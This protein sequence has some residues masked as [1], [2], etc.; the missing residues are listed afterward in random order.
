ML[1]VITATSE[2]VAI[3][4]IVSD[5]LTRKNILLSMKKAQIAD[6]TMPASISHKLTFLPSEKSGFFL[7]GII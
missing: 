6:S 3:C 2:T 1:M 4:F 5:R 7:V